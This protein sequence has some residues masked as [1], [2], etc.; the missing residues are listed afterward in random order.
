LSEEEIVNIMQG[1]VTFATLTADLRE[2]LSASAA[3]SFLRR[4]TTRVR[5]AD[6][7]LNRVLSSAPNEKAVRRAAARLRDTKGVVGVSVCRDGSVVGLSCVD[8]YAT[9]VVRARP[10][11][12]GGSRQFESVTLAFRTTTV[13][14]GKRCV[15]RR[16]TPTVIYLEAHALARFIERRPLDPRQLAEAELVAWLDREHPAIRRATVLVERAVDLG[17]LDPELAATFPVPCSAGGLWV[18]EPSTSGEDRCDATVVTYLGASCLSPEQ[19]S[20]VTACGDGDLVGSL[21]AYPDAL[22]RMPRNPDT[23]DG[24]GRLGRSLSA[25]H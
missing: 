18:V 2:R 17:Y 15:P 19:N 21:L 12:A 22:R 9:E 8:R 1:M 7:A 10:F 6:A 25:L 16:A 13:H 23:E 4:N 3:R 24:F 5:S 11:L 14:F 20:F